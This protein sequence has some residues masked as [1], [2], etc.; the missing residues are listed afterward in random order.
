METFYLIQFI[1][2]RFQIDDFVTPKKV[3]H[4]REYDTAPEH[5]ALY[6]ILTKHK[7]IVLVAHGNNIT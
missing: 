3:R 6:V 7:E 1:D 5:T 4:F 2:Q